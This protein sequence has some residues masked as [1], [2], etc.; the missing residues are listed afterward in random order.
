MRWSSRR[1][2]AACEESFAALMNPERTTAPDLDE[3]QSQ[4]NLGHEHESLT[5]P[6]DLHT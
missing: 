1:V 6:L 3:F 5:C 4:D 2:P